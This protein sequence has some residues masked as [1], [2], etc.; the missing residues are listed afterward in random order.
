M[1]RKVVFSGDYKRQLDDH[2]AGLDLYNKGRVLINTKNK[3]EGISCLIESATKYNNHNAMNVLGEIYDSQGNIPEAKRWFEAVT[4]HHHPRYNDQM[5]TPMALYKL[6]NLCEQEGNYVEA[7]SWYQRA[8]A[9]PNFNKQLPAGF[10]KP[11]EAM[12]INKLGLLLAKEGKIEEAIQWLEQ[13]RSKRDSH[14]Y[15]LSLGKIYFQR[16]QLQEA[17]AEFYRTNTSRESCWYLG[18]IALKEHDTSQA[19]IWFLKVADQIFNV[20]SKGIIINIAAEL[21]KLYQ[22]EGNIGEAIRYFTA[23]IRQS[24]EVEVKQLIDLKFKLSQCHKQNSDPEKYVEIL[25]ELANTNQH[26]ESMFNL[27][28]HFVSVGDITQ[29]VFWYQKAAQ[30]NHAE[31]HICLGEYFFR[32]ADYHGAEKHLRVGCKQ[33]DKDSMSMLSLVIVKKGNIDEAKEIISNFISKFSDD[34]CIYNFAKALLQSSHFLEAQEYFLKIVKSNTLTLEIKE[35]IVRSLEIIDEQTS[36]LRKDLSL[37]GTVPSSPNKNYDTAVKLEQAL[38]SKQFEI[39]DLERLLTGACSVNQRQAD[40]GNT[41]LHL[42]AQLNDV[43]LIRLFL[44]QEDVNLSLLNQSGQ[45]AFD[46]SIAK[47]SREIQQIIF[48]HIKGLPEQK[49]TIPPTK[50]HTNYTLMYSLQRGV[51]MQIFEWVLKHFSKEELNRKM[52]DLDGKPRLPT[53]VAIESAHL[54]NKLKFVQLLKDKLGHKFNKQNILQAIATYDLPLLEYIIQACQVA[55]YE[56]EDLLYAAIRSRSHEAVT[57]LL[58]NIENLEVNGLTNENSPLFTA[59]E[60]GAVE[61]VL[62]LLSCKN[63]NVN[64]VINNSQYKNATAL[65]I[66]AAKGHFNV[67]KLLLQKRAGVIS[68]IPAQDADNDSDPTTAEEIAEKLNHKDIAGRLK[69]YRELILEEFMKQEEEVG[70]GVMPTSSHNKNLLFQYEKQDETLLPEESL[71][72]KPR[73]TSKL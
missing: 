6:G 32:L 11:M 5:A 24:T 9:E 37:G 43:D 53:D 47:A 51:S 52:I 54:L 27:G 50:Y 23:A 41:M 34:V 16:G 28:Q 49:D 57:Y 35:N 68:M 58:T 63:I 36:S 62:K 26:V 44:K 71:S 29:G 67:V 7:R 22:D 38:K 61:V 60:L 15:S 46:L 66:A 70:G 31:A 30:H 69:Q 14:G 18:Q 55:D 33:N 48:N 20:G 56:H 2:N 13:A 72:D 40:T 3:N 39:Q 21:A 4:R 42:A 73:N 8:A 1:T 59:C 17:K 19:K 65:W 64:Q 10:P 12:A 45:T 25:Q